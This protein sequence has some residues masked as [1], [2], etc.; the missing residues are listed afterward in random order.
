M[1]RAKQ[2]RKKDWEYEVIC[3]FKYHTFIDKHG[4]IRW[5][6]N[7]RVPPQEVLDRYKSVNAPFN[8][9]KAIKARKK[10]QAE[11]IKEYKESQKQ[12]KRTPE[13]LAEMRATFG[14]GAVIEDVITGE[15]IKL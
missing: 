8:M 4:V 1:Q 5:K 7:K 3:E 13:E 12:R 15:K 10:E 6:S 11:M 14:E 2:A 9:E